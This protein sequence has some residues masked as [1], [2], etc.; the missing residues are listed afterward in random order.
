MKKWLSVIPMMLVTLSVHAAI[1]IKTGEKVAF[2][3]DS[4]TAQG[5]TSPHGYMRLVAAGLEC[6]G[7]KIVPIPVG[8]GGQTS[9]D[10]LAR[11]K[12]DVLDKKPDWVTVSCGM[13]DV[14]RL[15]LDQ[16][17]TNMN[18]IVGQCQSA[19][20]KV[21][22]FTT[23]T[24]RQHLE[25]FSTALRELAGEKKCLLVDL[26]LVF[27]ETGKKTD[28]LHG[29][30]YD[31]VHMNPEGNI[32]IAKTVLK[33]LGCTDSQ[34]VKAYETWLDLPNAGDISARVDVELN[35]KYFRTTCSLTLLQREKLLAAAQAAKFPTLMHWSKDLLASLMKKKVKPAGPY[36][37]FEAIFAEGKD[38]Q[39]QEE[40][41]NEFESEI[42]KIVKA[43]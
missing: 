21:V 25:E 14:L 40:L 6:N 36:D 3:G 30:T 4:I 35:K 19:G 8:V 17:K 38:K 11:L 5:W 41:Q 34:V 43:K 32:L 37:S 24:G 7:V 42:S 9:E 33:A 20:I 31:G 22:L 27:N 15:S 18:Q 26:F 13:N 2:L 12:R 39:V 16:F 23:T 1:L 28:S 10:M 29:L